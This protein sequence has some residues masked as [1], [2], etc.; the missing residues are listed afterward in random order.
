[1]WVTQVKGTRSVNDALTVRLSR[2]NKVFSHDWS[3]IDFYF[4]FKSSCDVKTNKENPC[5]ERLLFL[6]DGFIH[7][8]RLITATRVLKGAKIRGGHV[9]CFPL[10]MIREIK[11]KLS[12]PLHIVMCQ[13]CDQPFTQRYRPM[14]LHRPIEIHIDKHFNNYFQIKK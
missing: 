7:A 11:E 9:K 4:I 12:L 14:A 3:L 10:Q 5:C 8:T 1:M 13:F 6:L 2:I